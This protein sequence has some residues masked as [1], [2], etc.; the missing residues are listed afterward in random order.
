M[1][2]D[3]ER[4]I[5]RLEVSQARFDKQL[6]RINGTVNRRATAMERRF[7]R[8]NGT[9]TAGFSRLGA[10]LTAAFA[11]AL[12]ARAAQRLIDSA[13]RIENALKVAG[14]AGEELARVQ[15]R[16]F[17][18]AQ[19]N[20][21]PVEAL[22]QLYSRAALVQKELG[23]STEELLGFTD[24]VAVALRV[25]GKSASESSGALLQLSQALGSGVV[26]AEEFNSILEGA[27]PIAQAAAA[28]LKEAGGSVSKLRTLVIE[29]EVSSEAFF[30]AFEAGSVVLEDKVAGAVFTVAQSFTRIENAL[31][32][33]AG[34]FDDGADASGRMA[35]S[36]A[37]LAGVIESI[38]FAGPAR[39]LGAW[40]DWLERGALAAGR[41][42][43]GLADGRAVLDFSPA[44]VS[45]AQ[46]AG[47]RGGVGGGRGARARRDPVSLADFAAPS[48]T[49]G[50]K[51]KRDAFQREARQ[52][53]ERTG[54]IE[55]MTRA[56]AA[57]NPLI[58]DFGLGLEKA[59]AA[60]E[61]E[62]A[63]RREGLEITPELRT[64]IDELAGAYAAAGAAAEQ[65]AAEQEGLRQGAAEFAG[66][67]RDALGGFISDLREGKSASEALANSLDRVADRLIDIALDSLFSGGVG[68][69][70]GGGIGGV[71]ASLFHDGGIAGR[72]GRSRHVPAAAFAGAP[73]Y[74][75]GGIAGM[76]P[77]EVPAILQR[78]EIVVPNM[79]GSR[80]LGGGAGSSVAITYA[81]TI[82]AGDLATKA[83]VR[84]VVDR[85]VGEAVRLS[86]AGQARALRGR[87]DALWP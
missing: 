15:D 22:T 30:R 41:F 60:A 86:Q 26:R 20:A 6:A 36:L 69:G 48:G 81:P 17:A 19:R 1:A 53:T 33:A 80:G 83:W 4:L 84:G 27:L 64:R 14:L 35:R 8:V 25:S 31:I 42:V 77:G 85:S 43:E 11:G 2:T 24:R 67:A 37:W 76:Q 46:P 3:V 56:Q 16:L 18:S 57:L 55:A 13:T 23:I 61:L 63:A 39:T 59:R 40:V 58:E 7:A 12:T 66:I 44:P 34:K 74:H 10:G 70:S 9:V 75:A 62:A 71:I 47:L 50:G 82:N 38:D 45:R 68:G 65:L 49:A 21:A 29:G 32:V 28:G 52:I 78:G 5:L 73:R 79:A 54:A 51:E 87:S 72:G